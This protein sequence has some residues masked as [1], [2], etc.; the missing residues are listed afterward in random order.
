M[1]RLDWKTVDKENF[2]SRLK[3]A[4]DYSDVLV[5]N[6]SCSSGSPVA[7]ATIREHFVAAVPENMEMLSFVLPSESTRPLVFKKAALNRCLWEVL[8]T[9]VAMPLCRSC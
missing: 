6:D 7:L 4:I 2:C 3:P 8:V 9:A 1:D 5:V